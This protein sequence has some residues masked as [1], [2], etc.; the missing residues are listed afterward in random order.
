M[1]HLANFLIV[2]VREEHAQ[3]EWVTPDN[4][5]SQISVW[6]PSSQR[7]RGWAAARFLGESGV[8][9]PVVLDDVHDSVAR[10]Y[11]AWPDRLYVIDARGR[12]AYQ[13]GP[14]PFGFQPDEVRRFLSS[15]DR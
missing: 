6:Q 12:V 2:Y 9:I 3:D 15:M 10:A 11:G 7:E 8:T 4:V 14:G 5:K 13:G 1:G